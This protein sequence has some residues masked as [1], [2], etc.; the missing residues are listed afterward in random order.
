MWRRLRAGNQ[1]GMYHL[2]LVAL[3]G[4]I[5]AGG[6]HLTSLAALRLLGPGF[7]LGTL[8]VNVSGSLLMGVIA[9]I[10]AERVPIGAEGLRLFIATGILGGYTT[11]SAFSLETVMLWQRGQAG[12]AIVY[13]AASVSMSLAALLA[14]LW[15]A[16]T[17]A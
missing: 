11:F 4:A 3:G 6:R 13:V 17:G 9:G 1:P 16:R 15:L 7:P 14:G 10:L 8:F 2:G 12:Q 5:G